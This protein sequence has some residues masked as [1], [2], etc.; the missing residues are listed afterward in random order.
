MNKK[1]IILLFCSLLNAKPN[2][3]LV[4]NVIS[5]ACAP[6]G[7]V[8]DI[9]ANEG[10]KTEEYLQKGARVVAV[11]P[12]PSCITILKQKYGANQRVSII[13]KAIAAKNG[14][15]E[16]FI[17]SGASG[18]SSLSDKWVKDGR[19][20]KINKWDKKIVVETIT[21]DELIKDFGIPN[22]CKI[23]VEGFELQV[24]QGLSASIPLI[25]FEFT[26]EFID[27]LKKCINRLKCLGYY[28]FNFA[29]D[30][31]PYLEFDEWQSGESVISAI[32]YYS[33]IDPNVWGDVYVCAE[34]RK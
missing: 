4:D 29:R 8:F 14:S 16:M 12:Q 11:D 33:Q 32:T 10:I 19:F 20:S 22:F 34:N 1:L 5:S 6:G 31:Q 9:G 27:D 30:I 13:E 7:L 24:L 3:Q 23:D 2:N 26:G 28:S 15:V 21:I 18:I 17:C 25:S